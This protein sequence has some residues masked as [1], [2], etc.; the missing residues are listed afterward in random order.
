MEH[1]P[2]GG[3]NPVR[4]GEPS[5]EKFGWRF[6]SGDKVIQTEN[7]Y[8]KDVFNGDVGI[9]ESID[10]VEQQVAIRFDDRIVKYD[11]GE[12][13]ELPLAYAV[14]IHKVAGVGVPGCSDPTRDATLYALA[15][16]PHLHGD[17]AGQAVARADRAKCPLS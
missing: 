13:D 8:D 3:L 7:D 2:T 1:R 17:Y 16:K 11:F 4:P 12:L 5:V 10:P 6:L 14:T 15:K 9:V